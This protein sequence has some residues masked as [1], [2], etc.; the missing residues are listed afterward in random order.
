MAAPSQLVGHALGHYR[1]IEQ[2]GAGGMGE[3]YR[4]HD[5]H[6]DRDVALKVLPIGVLGDVSARKRFRK[7]ALIISRLNHPNIATVFD[8]DSQGAVDF[9]A[10]ELIAGVTLSAK[11]TEGP[12]P[13]PEIRRLGAQLVEGLA[14]AHTQGVLHRD[15][16]PGNLMI[17]SE[18]R[19]KI[20]D[21]GLATLRRPASDPDLT[22]SLSKTLGVSGTLP[23]MSPEQLRGQPTDVRSDIYAAGI[24]L[25]EMAAGCRPFPQSQGA[26]L[27]GAILHQTPTS[28]SKHNARV[29]PAL[30]AIILRTL[31]RDPGQRYQSVHEL[32]VAFDGLSAG[33]LPKASQKHSP[34]PLGM[35]A[36]L[37]LFLV[38][39]LGLILGTNVGGI[40]ERLIRRAD[41]G[42]EGA[43]PSLSFTRPRRSVAVLGFKNLSGRPEEVWLS[44]ALSEML[45]T[46]L[47]A[48]EKLRTIP[49]ENVAQMRINLSLPEAD[50][51]S[52]E[53]LT[54]IRKDLGAD[55][56]IVGSYLAL[57]NG[58]VRLDVRL[59]DVQ[60]GETLASVTESGGE[61]EVADL[62]VRAGAQL[63]QKLGAGTISS[64]DVASVR[65][66]LPSSPQA[67]RLYSEGLAKLRMFD[68]LGARNLLQKAVAAE[69]NFSLAH[70]ALSKTWSSLGY[71]AQAQEQAQKAFE[72]SAPLSREERLS[73]EGRYR[74]SKNEWD[75]AIEIYRTLF[76]FFPDNLEYGL[77]LSDV[78]TSAGKGVNALA[79]IEA[80]R[81]LPP[82]ASDDARIDYAE[83]STAE[84][85]GDYKQERAAAVKAAQKGELQG[86]KLLVAQARRAE[87]WTLQQLGEYR[88]AISSCEEARRIF[89]E[90]G[91][92][93][94]LASSLNSMASTLYYQGDLAGASARYKEALVIF[95]ESGDRK[96]VASTVNNLAAV[97]SDQGDIR[98][99]KR[100]Y[101]ESLAIS[102]EVG[103]EA[104][105]ALALGNIGGELF[106]QGDLPGAKEKYDE[107]QAIF[108]KIG[109]QDSVAQGLGN[110]AETLFSQGEL[111]G[112]NRALEEALAIER[113][114][115]NKSDSAFQLSVLADIFMAKG[116]LV[117]ARRNYESALKLRAE[118]GNKTGAA[119]NQV[120]LAELFVEEGHPANAEAPVRESI[121]FFR[122]EKL[123]DDEIFGE[124]V[125]AEA[126][127]ALGRPPD[128]QKE[129]D[130]A[131]AA[132]AKSQYRTV[133]LNIAIVAARVRAALG[134][135][136]EA[137]ESLK[138][139]SAEAK[140]LGFLGQQFEARLL[141]GEIEMKSGPIAAGRARLAALEKDAT[142]KGFGLIA[143]RAAAAAKG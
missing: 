76:D 30:E 2:I 42:R 7:E 79:T 94:G 5:E 125:L 32:R 50:S 131:A 124:T 43:N 81:K 10:M 70:S 132:M 108:R 114:T 66:A 74:A 121:A 110:I 140:R 77:E 129:I 21:F 109:N 27:I 115:G 59:Q 39:L 33:V 14:A 23:Y 24:V 84:S 85:L 107:S 1:I 17:S 16:K 120:S 34:W 122:R 96:G 75:K 52:K 60:A 98:G 65:A 68:S 28:P 123:R 72:L 12:L 90:A 138:A 117:E 73:V 91:N 104:G 135:T 105:A 130:H 54:R 100:M 136:S 87:C 36:S 55:E 102:R 137:R 6:L 38:L 83:A 89:F 78:Q 63:R 93:H 82:P 44:T 126:L 22:Q 113:A 143:R 26:E 71:D 128:A 118:I 20:L 67:A 4:A 95:R 62:V 64:A 53:T 11:L 101:E 18:G 51:Y 133:L 111:D 56:V 40:R 3:V 141:L 19:L 103:D 106:Q 119:E 80:L 29:T 48:G 134:K 92:R 45:T 69:P 127:L 8:F 9:L 58:Q 37:A 112:A 13:E 97:L 41:R 139:T 47:A 49:G 35:T 46:E 142:A 25:Y 15:L 31:E 88:G 116:N 86:A 61:A 57:G 99:S